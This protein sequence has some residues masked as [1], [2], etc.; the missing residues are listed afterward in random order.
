MRNR[1]ENTER[2]QPRIRFADAHRLHEVASPT[3]RLRQLLMPLVTG[4]VETRRG[5][6]AWSHQV[7]VETL[8]DIFRDD[9]ERFAGPKGKHQHPRAHNRWGSTSTELEFGGRRISVERPRV[10]RRGGG[11][12]AL[13]TVK[14]LQEFDPLPDTVLNQI[15]LG[16]STRGYDTSVPPPPVGT[17]SRGTSRSAV[18]RQL[19]Q[20]MEEKMR[21]ALSAPLDEVRLVGL[22]VDGIEIA[23]YTI[24]VALGVTTSGAKVPLGLH[25]GS[26]ENAAVCTTLLNRLVERGLKVEDPIL[27]VVDGG[28]GIRKA[29]RDVFGH[30]AIVQRCTVH[31]RRNVH[32]HLPKNRQITVDRQL[33]DAY[34][35]KTADTARKRLRQIISWLARNGE[36][37]AVES[38]KEGLEETL[39]V[40]KLGLPDVLRKFFSTTNAIENLMGGVRK[41]TRNVKR[42]RSGKMACRWVAAAVE[43]ARPRFHNI[44]GH[45]SLP[46]LVAALRAHAKTLDLQEQVS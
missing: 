13:P 19:T 16:V 38:L 2:R 41:V 26:T 35:S 1:T 12:V 24:V 8:G 22:L 18:S 44:K 37:S 29:L 25:Q 33:Q 9:V 3:E 14:Y 32:D 39:T 27:C 40:I 43:K 10:R 7:G 46:V 21:A 20:R 6:M 30:L 36:E 5:L 28:K 42:W 34:A 23:D 15:L 11:E 17:R 4:A 45:K 31:K